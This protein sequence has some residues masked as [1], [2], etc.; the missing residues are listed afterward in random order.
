MPRRPLPAGAA[1]APGTPYAWG[2]NSQG[3]LGDGTTTNRSVPVRVDGP[4]TSRAIVVTVPGISDARRVS[5]GAERSL[6]LSSAGT[7]PPIDPDEDG[8]RVA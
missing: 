1:S 7:T 5:G 6:A 4:R 8:Q 3:R 2:L